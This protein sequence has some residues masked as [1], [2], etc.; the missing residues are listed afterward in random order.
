MALL[1]KQRW[2][3]SNPI[4]I[5]NP[6]TDSETHDPGAISAGDPTCLKP[7]MYKR[8]DCLRK[9]KMTDLGTVEN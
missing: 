8:F 2:R 5:P 4:S 3:A 6:F 1:N 9:V 7:R